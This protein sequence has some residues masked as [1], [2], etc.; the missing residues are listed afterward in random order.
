MEKILKS[1]IFLAIFLDPS[2]ENG[3]TRI[4]QDCL[5]T[6]QRLEKSKGCSVWMWL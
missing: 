3:W 1:P 6:L 2:I 5:Q 4:L